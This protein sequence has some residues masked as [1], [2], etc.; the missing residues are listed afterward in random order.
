MMLEPGTSGKSSSLGVTSARGGRFLALDGLRGIA[1]V[2]VVFYHFRFP[3]HFTHRLFFENSYVAVDLFFILSG[4]VIYATYSHNIADMFSIQRFIGLRIFRIYPLHFAVLL[5]F[6]CLELAKLVVF[7]SDP[8]MPVHMPFTGSNTYDALV[9]NLFLLQGL[10]FMGRPTWNYP[11]WS[12]SCEFVAYL[13]FAMAAYTGAFRSKVFFVVCLLL[14]ISGYCTLAFVHNTLDVH[15]WGQG[16]VRCLAGFF[17]GVFIFEFVDGIRGK[18]LSVQ[19]TSLVGGCEVGVALALVLTMSFVSGTAILS[20]VPILIFAVAIFQLDR[21]PIAKLLASRPIQF[22]GRISYS[23]Y[24][25]HMFILMALSIALKRIVGI[26]F[27]NDP[28]TQ[29]PAFQIGEWAGDAIGLGTIVIVLA[30]SVVTCI[31]IEEPARRYGRRMFQFPSRLR[32]SSHNF[33][34]TAYNGSTR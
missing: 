10:P 14:S 22:L 27:T 5:I 12:I 18:R 33:S 16:L 30:C 31:F 32:D 28:V 11:S 7:R 23:V 13:L 17:F 15:N 21:G 26:P 20:I 19:R 4:F 34:V 25:V 6:V 2:L 24:M 8:T 1:A 3:N 9:A 29:A